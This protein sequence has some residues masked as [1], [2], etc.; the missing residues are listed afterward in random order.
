MQLPFKSDFIVIFLELSI[1][2]ANI[3][4]IPCK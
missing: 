2:I 4:S 1:N 3:A